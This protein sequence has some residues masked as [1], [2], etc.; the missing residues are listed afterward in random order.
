MTPDEVMLK[1]ACDGVVTWC[2]ANS[3]ASASW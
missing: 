2:R 1:S 3:S